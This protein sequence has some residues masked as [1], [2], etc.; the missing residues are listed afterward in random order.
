MK[1]QVYNWIKGLYYEETNFGF[2]THEEF[3]NSDGFSFLEEIDLFL[4]SISNKVDL[5]H[6]AIFQGRYEDTEFT[7]TYEEL[8]ENDYL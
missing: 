8:L 2:V 3:E 6:I 4:S 5:N 7:L 1:W